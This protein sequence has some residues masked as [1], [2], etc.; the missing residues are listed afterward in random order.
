MEIAQMS[1]LKKDKYEQATDLAVAMAPKVEEIHIDDMGLETLGD[2]IRYNERAR[3][4]NKRL[5]ICR[6]KIKQCPVELHPTEK[7]QLFKNDKS[8]HKQ[9]VLISNDMIHF[10]EMIEPGQTYDLPRCVIEHLASKGTPQWRWFTNADG[11][12]E[13]RM[14]HKEPRFSI[15]TIYE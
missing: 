8:T 13:T 5:K 15:R 12:R 14:S 6:Y 2:Y 7:V 10:D 9:K 3:A 4:A 1:R 11:S